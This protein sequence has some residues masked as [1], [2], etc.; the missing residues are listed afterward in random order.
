MKKIF[1]LIAAILSMAGI[2]SANSGCLMYY[3]FENIADNAEIYIAN[4]DSI[5]TSS[6]N[7]GIKSY[8]FISEN[9]SVRLC[10]T[11]YTSEEM[12]GNASRKVAFLFPEYSLTKYPDTKLVLGYD[13][14]VYERKDNNYVHVFTT[15]D[16]GKEISQ[17][18]AFSDG[19]S[20]KMR[21]LNTGNYIYI[22]HGVNTEYKLTVD[23]STEKF[24]FNV[25]ENFSKE[26]DFKYSEAELS[27]I[28]W[29]PSKNE[30]YSIDNIYAWVVPNTFSVT[31]YTKEISLT[32][33][34]IS[35]Y[36]SAPADKTTLDKISVNNSKSGFSVSQDFNE[37]RIDI[38]LDSVSYG[39][40]YTV[41]FEEGFKD[42]AG[43]EM[44]T[45]IKVRAAKYIPSE[46]I[47][48]LMY[49]DFE[50][51][52]DNAEIYIANTDGITT[53]STNSGIKKYDFIYENGSTRLCFTGY[54]SGE[55]NGNASR[56][57]M[58]E[59]P[60]YSSEKYPDTK[61]VLGYDETV[62][63]RTDNNYTHMVT[64]DNSGSQM[65]QLFAFSDGDSDKMRML[66]TGNYIYISH[67]VNNEY[68]LTADMS[69]KKFIFNVGENF[70]KE[71]DFKDSLTELSKIAW[72]PA[73]DEKYSIDNIYAWAVPNTL[74][75]KYYTKEITTS[76]KKIS[77]YLSAPADKTALD[78]ISVNNSK[79]G[80]SVTQ[81][82]SEARLDI[83][84][85]SI[86]YGKK[87]TVSFEDGFKDIAGNTMT[88]D[89]ETEAESFPEFNI[90]SECEQLGN[91]IT[92]RVYAENP[93]EN[94]ASAY[95]IAGLYDENGVLMQ[96][97]FFEGNFK[98][99][100]K[101]GFEGIFKN[102]ANS[103][104][105]AYAAAKEG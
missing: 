61:L 22:S 100:Q 101:H 56:Q 45:D 105:K 78:K 58:F 14:T 53:S 1:A 54:K 47:N 9:N 95:V 89:I 42:I 11:G 39:D 46:N 66:N 43:N 2:A 34:K 59:F 49:Y 23:M 104:I 18:F 79:S 82:F 63:E 48:C 80:F 27:K 44:T 51:I 28:V 77:I 55:I 97:A 87:Y 72:S 40:K 88:A 86:S 32:E 33:K 68:K 3:D 13:E 73:K 70:S 75:I 15:N 26:Y 41:S 50:N 24:V 37:A 92:Y 52:A 20:D 81:D 103:S 96:C 12:S 31:D 65:S 5:T 71:Y 38:V 7:N 91:D 94:A 74:S 99:M 83:L 69:T 25:G 4:T 85:D 60:E 64:S 16:S 102:C 17:L 6:T 90:T 36:L 19:D 8:D 10:F 76:E 30:K 29:S 62:Y 35:V 21:M 93:S 67:G 57:F 98:P 84:L